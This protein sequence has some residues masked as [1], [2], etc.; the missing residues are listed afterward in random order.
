MAF[1]LARQFGMISAIRMGTSMPDIAANQS[2]KEAMRLTKAKLNRISWGLNAYGHLL[3]A[4][5]RQDTSAE[6][7]EVEKRPDDQVPEHVARLIQDKADPTV[8]KTMTGW[9]VRQYA[10]G[11]LRLEDLGT[12]YET[13]TMFQRYALRLPKGEQDLGRYQSLAAVWEVVSPI[14]EA[15]Q[16][17]LSG[18]AQKAVDK[19]KA[20]AESR[21]LRQDEDGF[22]IAVPLTEFAAKWWGKGTRWCT[23]AEKDNRF[24][25]YHKD[26]PLIVVVI[27]E[28]KEKGKFQLWATEGD[29][30]FMDAADNS[31]SEVLI[32]EY[33][34]RFEPILSFALRQNSWALE[35]V[36]VEFRTDE[37]CGIAVAHNGNALMYVPEKFRTEEMCRIAVEQD[38][39]ALFLV[40][41]KRCTEE[42]F[43]IAVAQDGFALE[44]VP[45]ALRS[46]VVC[47]IAVAQDGRSLAYVPKKLRT[48]D[49]CSIAVAQDGLALRY[50]RQTL[51]TD[52][53]CSIAV[54]Q[55]GDA[56]RWVPERLRSEAVCQ[57]ALAQYGRALEYV[58]KKLRTEDL[59]HIAVAQDGEALDFVPEHMRTEEMC[60]TAVAQ[61]GLTLEYVADHLRTD[62]MCRIAVAQNGLALRYVP[63]KLRTE[64]IYRI[65]V[66]QNGWVLYHVPEHIRTDEMCRTAVAQDGWALEYVPKKLRSEEMCRIAV[67]Q[68]S[69]ALKYVPEDLQDQMRALIP[70]PIPE[71][72][73]LLLDELALALGRPTSPGLSGPRHA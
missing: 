42:I 63:E 9:L 6:A 28:L 69:G 10:Y 3:A 30:Q 46:E 62:E 49:I 14:A 45:D 73:L 11:A 16:D 31:V 4:A 35:Y 29:V 53:M 67:V 66:A 1:F 26:A 44:Y 7:R 36:P 18:K 23:S 70:V 60:R 72:D 65:A 71:W 40:P 50:V 68:N 56:L 43:R 58:P 12:A 64:E 47:R 24:W 5:V 61:N 54:E 17:K 34:P 13:L 41:E 59:C 27:P 51:R 21:I 19:A 52:E 25:Q 57:I 22:T 2:L 48:D 8:A 32:T 37:M 38:G 39:V 15:E 20:H 33:W 55:N